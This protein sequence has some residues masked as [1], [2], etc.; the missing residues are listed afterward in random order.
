MSEE[1]EGLLKQVIKWADN[2]S[3]GDNGERPAFCIER[4]NNRW[5][6]DAYSFYDGGGELFGAN[7]ETCIAEVLDEISNQPEKE[8]A[9]E[10]SAVVSAVAR[11]KRISTAEAKTLVEDVGL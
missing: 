7:L 11:Y 9:R 4:R 2:A 1:L 5:E 10:R 8:K 3:V 6:V